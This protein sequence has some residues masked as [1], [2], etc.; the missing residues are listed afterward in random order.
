MNRYSSQEPRHV[1]R[2]LYSAMTVAI[3]RLLNQ[4]DTDYIIYSQRYSHLMLRCRRIKER[5]STEYRW[6]SEVREIAMETKMGGEL[7][8]RHQFWR[9]AIWNIHFVHFVLDKFEPKTESGIWNTTFALIKDIR[10]NWLGSLEEWMKSL[11]Y[12]WVE[13]K[14]AVQILCQRIENSIVDDIN[15]HRSNLGLQKD[16][17]YSSARNSGHAQN[18]RAPKK[19]DARKDLPVTQ[20]RSVNPITTKQKLIL[21]SHEQSTFL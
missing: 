20:S 16:N 4:F 7:C 18:S 15:K 2:L 12:R 3:F 17:M 9:L 5:I 11:E 1:K 21:I 10:Q 6:T 14:P 8:Q 19:S 13:Q